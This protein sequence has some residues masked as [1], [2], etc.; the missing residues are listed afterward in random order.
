MSYGFHDR[1]GGTNA[2][3]CEG[4]L[5]LVRP[6]KGRRLAGVCAG[7]GAALNVEPILVRLAWVAAALLTAVVPALIVYGITALV[8]PS[9]E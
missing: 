4:K 7:M 1:P 9:E 5:M 2:R 8:T 6:K 3:P